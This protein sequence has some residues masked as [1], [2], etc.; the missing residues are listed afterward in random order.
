ME[1]FDL[2]KLKIGS[3][4]FSQV[5]VTSHPRD[6]FFKCFG[7]DGYIG[8]DLLQDHILQIDLEAKKIRITKD[9]ESLSLVPSQ[10]QEMYLINHQKTP[11]IWL[12]FEKSSFKDLVMVDTGMHGIYD[13]S[14]DTHKRLLDNENIHLIAKSTG[15]AT[16]SAF[17]LEPEREQFLFHFPSIS[18][19]DFTLINYINKGTYA[20]N[21]RVGSKLLKYG[22]MTL[23]F[24]NE[25]FYF[26]PHQSKVLLE[27]EKLFFN[28]ASI[29]EKIIVGIV[30][31][32]K[33]Q[34]KIQFGDEIL[35]VNDWD[36][37]KIEFCDFVLGTSI[38]NN[39]SN[40][41]RFRSLKDSVFT[42]ELKKEKMVFGEY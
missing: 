34:E 11:Y 30:W 29:D 19:G 28:S 35:A 36:L 4:E 25:K 13:L 42:L 33:L 20:K 39:K 14:L 16:I 12:N 23:D 2:D 27:P 24:I 9:I 17:G 21:S 22:L 6:I 41:I 37:T 26:E 3:F 18:I 8:S 5:E 38:F 32:E 31:D 1:S 7:I 40:I 10:G 15:A